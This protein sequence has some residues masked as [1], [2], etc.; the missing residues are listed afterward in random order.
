MQPVSLSNIRNK[1]IIYDEVKINKFSSSSYQT[2]NSILLSKIYGLM[3]LTLKPAEKC[4]YWWIVGS[5][6]GTGHGVNRGA[7]GLPKKF[8]HL[9]S[10]AWGGLAI[11]TL[12]LA[13]LGITIR[14]LM[15]PGKGNDAIRFMDATKG[16]S[17]KKYVPPKLTEDTPIHLATY[18]VASLPTPIDAVKDMLPAEKRMEE[19]AIWLRKQSER[20]DLPLCI[21]MQEAFDTKASELFCNQ[22]KDLYPYAVTSA[23]WSNIPFIGGNSGLEFHSRV[24]IK[25]ASFYAFDDL[26]GF[27]HGRGFL[28]VELDLG[29]GRSALVYVTHTQAHAEQHQIRRNEIEL[30]RRQMQADRAMDLE[31]GEDRSGLY[32][33]MGDLNVANVDDET[34]EEIGEFDR[35]R[36]TGTTQLPPLHPDLF[37]DPYLEEHLPN[38]ERI[39]GKGRPRFLEH[40][41]RNSARPFHE[42]EVID[43]P[44]GTFY[45]GAGEDKKDRTKRGYGTKNF[46]RG[47]HNTI[48]GCRYDYILRLRSDTDYKNTAYKPVQYQGI[49]EIRHVLPE[50]LRASPVSDHALVS[51][52]FMKNEI[53]PRKEDLSDEYFLGNVQ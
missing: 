26:K 33:L 40:D 31:R 28:K 36:G 10:V 7:G 32:F 48:P 52:I 34:G 2:H 15:H 46:Y 45:Q 23:G 12:P 6:Q 42:M 9:K 49:A 19:F 13:I 50:N 35:L 8:A 18:N 16:L 25:S 29:E 17:T 21:G 39:E 38:G 47:P 27:C 11:L 14:E 44:K 51:A 1:L 41:V 24:P 37:D 5:R 20:G 53:Y 43:E 22:T 4:A 30:V 3:S